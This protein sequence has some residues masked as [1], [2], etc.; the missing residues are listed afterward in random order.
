MA[1]MMTGEA[2]AGRHGATP[3]S[4]ADLEVAEQFVLW[5]L[6]TPLEGAAGRGRLERG[7]ELAEGPAMG[8]ATLASF[9]SWFHLLATH[10]RRDLYLHRAPC[11]CLSA[12]EKAMLELVASAQA[13]DEIR[14][15]RVAAG[16][17]H[18]QAIGA[19]QRSSRVLAAALCR[20]GLCLSDRPRRPRGG[21]P[22]V[23]H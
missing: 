15:H 3:I 11:P 6:R 9:E 17:V 10:R 2:M 4:V 23:L 22:A 8:G 13:G 5:A 20:L 7:F 19:L 21:A 18:A 14:L 1:A 16:L 12:D